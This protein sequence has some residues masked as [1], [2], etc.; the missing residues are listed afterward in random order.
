MIQTW[1]EP[2]AYEQKEHLPQLQL[3]KDN[4]SK[5][6]YGIFLPDLIYEDD[7]GWTIVNAF[8]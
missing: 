3:E 4:K 7:N 2:T 5:V 1:I 6:I 8:F